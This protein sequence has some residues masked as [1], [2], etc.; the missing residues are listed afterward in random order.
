M[1]DFKKNK[2]NYCIDIGI[3]NI[4]WWFSVRRQ[5]LNNLIS[6]LNFSKKEWAIDVGCG[7]GSNLKVLKSK[8]MNVIGLDKSFNVLRTNIQKIKLPLVNGDL[9]NLPF[10]PNSFKLIIAMD[11]L[12]HLDNDEIGIEEIYR[13][14]DK[15]GILILTVPAFNFLWG[16]QDEI[17]GHK[18]RYLQKEIFKKLVSKNFCILK[19]SYFNFFFFFPILLTRRLIYILKLKIESENKINFFLLNSILKIIFSIETY[20]LRFF[21]FPFGVSILFLAKKE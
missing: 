12:E 18:R 3:E 4:H 15:G 1:K 19:S 14:L 5:I 9:H 11:V 13:I 8:E 6:N 17:T 2:E 16:L 10:K 7:V 20:W 21:S